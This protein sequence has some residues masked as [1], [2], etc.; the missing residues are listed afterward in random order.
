MINLKNLTNIN[1][2]IVLTILYIVLCFIFYNSKDR[3]QT[4]DFRQKTTDT[5]LHAT[6][7]ASPAGS[8]QLHDA[9]PQIQT[10][11]N[12]QTP[13]PNPGISLQSPELNKKFPEM[14][15]PAPELKID[16]DKVFTVVE[17]YPTFPGGDAARMKFLRDNI[18]YPAEA[19][20]KHTEGRVTVNFIVEK[21]GTVSNIKILGGIGNSCD[22]EALRVVKMMPKWNPGR[23]TGRP[24]RVS[25][26][27]PINFQL[28][29]PKK[30]FSH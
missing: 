17:E 1:L 20:K 8:L 9:N 11:N 23:Q 15:N 2:A 7:N 27:M 21:D 30:V 18:K 13:I 24:V 5:T 29:Y 12:N 19:I 10:N 28:S 3:T 14:I 22:E 26:N 25:F 4:T 6:E 16:E